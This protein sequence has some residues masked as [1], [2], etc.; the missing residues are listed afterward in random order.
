MILLLEFS[1]FRELQLIL[2]Y[3]KLKKITYPVSIDA[4]WKNVRNTYNSHCIVRIKNNYW[5]GYNPYAFSGPGE[6]DDWSKLYNVPIY[7]IDYV[8]EYLPELLI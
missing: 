7:T 5:N 3:F 8:I 4:I 2:Q 6:K 1:S